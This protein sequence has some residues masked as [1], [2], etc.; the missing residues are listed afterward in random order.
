M[1]LLTWRLFIYRVV[2][3][4]RTQIKIDAAQ[5][6]NVKCNFTHRQHT[7]NIHREQIVS[8]KITPMLKSYTVKF[9][10][11]GENKEKAFTAK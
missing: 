3:C 10:M 8:N 5:R 6:H 11:L 7:H 4:N 2:N 1:E 9:K